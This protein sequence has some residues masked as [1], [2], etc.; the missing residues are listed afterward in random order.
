[1]NLIYKKII[2]LHAYN[3]MNKII[4]GKVKIYKIIFNYYIYF[5][6]LECTLL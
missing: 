6:I 3:I 1:M 4:H 2:M 5:I